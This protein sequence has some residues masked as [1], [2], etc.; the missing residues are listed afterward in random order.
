[1]ATT[2]DPDYIAKYKESDVK[3]GFV[4]PDG[5]IKFPAFDP[6][7]DEGAVLKIVDGEPK[8]VSDEA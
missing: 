6:E 4:G 7:E 5:M 3:N 1:M 8:W 2:F